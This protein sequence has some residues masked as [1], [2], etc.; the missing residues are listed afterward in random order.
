MTPM[1][2]HTTAA[3]LLLATALAGCGGAARAPASAT[4]PPSAAT[5]A[6]SPGFP[7]TPADLEFMTGML[8]HHAQAILM[9]GW[10][11]SHGAS[12]AIRRLSERI[13]VGQQDESAIMERWLQDRG[14]PVP[15]ADSA[16]HGTSGMDHSAMEHAA[17]MPGM[18]TA[19]QL[20][21]LD[22]A[23]GAEFDRLFLTFMIEHH[24]GALTMVDRLFG[25]AGAAQ[26]ETVFRMASDVYAEQSTEIARMEKMLAALPSDGSTP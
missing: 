13:V 19:E 11:P 25:A 24:R 21:R 1:T 16:A 3:T 10:A 14:E 5:T 20:A 26:D 23:R 2:V 15:G 18:L 12:D 4:V 7:H 22:R 9:A 17:L 8:R 6:A